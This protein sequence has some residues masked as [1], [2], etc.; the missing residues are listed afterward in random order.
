MLRAIG[1]TQGKIKRLY[2]YEAFLLV[3]S[4]CALGILIGMTVGYTMVMQQNMFLKTSM[5]VF[6]PWK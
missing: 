4:S 5:G 6:F 2:F 1:I 3:M